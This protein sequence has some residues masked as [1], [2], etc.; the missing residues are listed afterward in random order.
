MKWMAGDTKCES[1]FFTFADVLG[2]TFRGT[3]TAVG[4]I[5]HGNVKPSKDLLEDLYKPGF[6]VGKVAGLLPLYA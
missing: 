4:H 5:V 3:H 1:D 2:Y 6:P